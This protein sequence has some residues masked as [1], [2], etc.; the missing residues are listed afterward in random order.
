M[1]VLITGGSGLL[2]SAVAFHFKDYFDTIFTYT[3]HEVT[4]NGC[5]STRLDIRERKD[6]LRL[7]KEINPDVI[8]HTAALVGMNICEKNQEL[9]FKVNFEGTKNIIDAANNSKIIYIST[10]YVFDG[11]KGNYKETDGANPINVYGK[12]KLHG[13]RL[14]DTEDNVIVRTSI[15]GWNIIKERKSFS[16]W[17]IDELKNSRKLSVFVDQFNSMMLVNNCAEALKE[18]VEKDIRGILNIASGERTSKYDFAVKCAEVFDFD[19]KLI[20][21]IKNREIGDYEKRPLDV[22]LDITK[23]KRLL[24]TKLLDVNESLSILK[25]LHRDQYLDNFQVNT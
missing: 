10:D 16:T 14:I 5:K 13:E 2:G 1:K 15:Y 20:S 24:K 3:S 25:K 12:T 22:S 6:T 18:V 8:V 11:K 23:A 7:I 19:K 4:I 21:E 17:V 9:A